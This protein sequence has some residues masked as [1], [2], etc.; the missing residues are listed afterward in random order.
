VG[1]DPRTP[2]L[3]GIGAV[4]QREDDP[5]RAQEPCA[6]MAEALARAGDD[7]GDASLLAEADLVAVPRG[8]W[9]Y[10]DPGRLVAERIGAARARTLCAEI[11]VLQTT[12]FAEAARAIL[13]GAEVVLV[14]GGEA[15]HRAQRLRAAGREE[16]LAAQ[17]PGT[18]PDRTLR[19]E[20]EIVHPVEIA[21]RFVVPVAQYALIENA[22]RREAG[23]SID[24]HR[25]ELAAF[26]AGFA[27]VARSNPDAWSREGPDED[28]LLDSE[29]RNPM[30]AFP[31]GRL[32]CSQWTVDQAAGLV[33]CSAARAR[34]AGIPESR[35]VFPR[36]V[37]ESN[38]MR[39]LVAR[40][41]LAR[42]PGF[43]VAWR[44][45]LAQAE[46]APESIGV[47]E[48]YS[49]FPSA[50]SVQL[51]ELGLPAAPTPSV[52]GGMAFAGGPLNN[53]VLQA[54]TRVAQRLR[55]RGGAAVV[56]AV[57]GMLTKQ[58]VSLWSCEP[59]AAFGYADVSAEA[60][61]AEAPRRVVDAVES[62]GT[63]AGYTVVVDPGGAL[64]SLA[65]VDLDEGAR[66]LVAS[67]DAALA[68]EAMQS[69]LA[70]ARVRVAVDGSF[71][72]A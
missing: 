52:T 12:L 55:E 43:G 61:R 11:G 58:G 29:R 56:T 45:V 54:M 40:A 34:R 31:Y 20:G 39:P 67:P 42:S 48:L 59:G 23:L 37:A 16:A 6:L 70:G 60:E 15:R 41:G 35:W 4:V 47:R 3:V 51:C 69:E 53:F 66:A 1:G 64:R 49:C 50:V 19:P 63:V 26:W 36:A 30:L 28:A 25:R 9:S 68:R 62:Q 38:H 32:H 17:P 2:V 8:F 22:L 71:A 24:A 21:R 46:L 18:A 65:L 27:R 13:E 57:S 72:P 7:A 5:Q 10:A 44:R 33:F 14:T